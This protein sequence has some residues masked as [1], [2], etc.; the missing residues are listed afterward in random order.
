MASHRTL[1]HIDRA[2][3]IG[4]KFDELRERLRQMKATNPELRVS[5]AERAIQMAVQHICR[6][7]ESALTSDNDRDHY[8]GL[9]ETDL[10]HAEKLLDTAA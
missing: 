9:A 10:K 6:A 5:K 8:L 2:N 3:D 4:G 1:E 7:Y